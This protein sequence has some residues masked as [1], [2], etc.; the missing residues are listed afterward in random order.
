MGIQYWILSDKSG[1]DHS[2]NFF[3]IMY[4]ANIA[5]CCV[6][7]FCCFYGVLELLILFEFELALWR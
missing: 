2:P 3:F 5:K 4:W 6:V 7:S 1:Y